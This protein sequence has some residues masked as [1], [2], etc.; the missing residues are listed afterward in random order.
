MVNRQNEADI[1]QEKLKAIKV[2]IE[3]KIKAADSLLATG[4]VTEAIQLYEQALCLDE[5][6]TEIIHKLAQALKQQGNLPAAL[7]HYHQTIALNQQKAEKI[8]SK[9]NCSITNSRAEHN[10]IS[11]LLN[12][13]NHQ[14]NSSAAVVAVS[15][16]QFPNNSLQAAQLY[17]EQAQSYMEEEK[18]QA[19]ITACQKALKISVVMPEAYKIW[20]NILQ[21]QGK[22]TEAMGYYAEALAIKSDYPEVYAS[23]GSIYAEK[24]RWHK[25]LAYYER[26]IALKP[27]W[28]KV[29]KNMAKVSLML[30]KPNLALDYH[31]QAVK[32][33]ASLANAQE[34]YS[35]A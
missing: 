3:S 21:K 1:S 30:D 7:A 19:A 17:L 26:A 24:R 8:V 5:G 22:L 33:D 11:F 25:A 16:F 12:N 13:H 32:Q 4:R 27:D 35:I 18:W 34:Y 31:Y 2:T 10:N 14:F 28:A 9:N 23:V 20:G 15:N 6:N 29:Y